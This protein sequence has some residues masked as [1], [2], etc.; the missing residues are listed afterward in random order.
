LDAAFIDVGG[1]S[2]VLV[3]RLLE[4]GCSDI[5]V[6]DISAP[7]LLR[8]RERLGMASG[9]VVWLV[10]DITLFSPPRTYALWHDRAVFHFLTEPAHRRQYIAALKAG[11]QPG[12]Q[13]LLAT[14]S[15]E[16]PEQC[17][18]L[19]VERYGVARITK[20]LG[21][22]FRLLET[23]NETHQTPW[24]GK[25]EFAWYRF[26]FSPDDSPKKTPG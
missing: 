21:D 15:P 19:P 11:L 2:S 17:S 8:S 7:A 20:T 9:N 22:A 10:E 12:G 16:G 4:Q 13:F 26:L 5:T 1:G 14:F 6:L 24:G 3:D 25:Q 18:G 23:C